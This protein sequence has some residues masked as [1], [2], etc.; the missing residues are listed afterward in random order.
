VVDVAVRPPTTVACPSC[1]RPVELPLRV[2]SDPR[3][4]RPGSI[5]FN[6]AVDDTFLTIFEDHVLADPDVHADFLV[7]DD[8]R[9]RP[10]AGQP[11]FLDQ[12]HHHELDNERPSR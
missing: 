8:D 1:A 4:T 7:P 6:I 10:A 3:N 12:I 5:A 9:C 2:V 11:Y